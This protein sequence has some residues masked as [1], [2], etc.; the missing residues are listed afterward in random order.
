MAKRLSDTEKWMDSWFRRLPTNGKI[1]WLYILDRCD[2]A[3][4]WEVDYDLFS[5]L[6]GVPITAQEAESMLGDRIHLFDDG[7]KIWVRKFIDF[8]NGPLREESESKI[9]QLIIR[10]LKAHDLWIPYTMGINT[11]KDRAIVKERVKGKEKE[12]ANE[13]TTEL[14]IAFNEARLAYPGTRRGFKDEWA[15][16]LSRHG[17]NKEE[18]VPLLMAGVKRY[19]RK[20]AEDKTQKQYIKNFQGWITESRWTE[21]YP[22]WNTAKQEKAAQAGMTDEERLRE[23]RRKN[24][25]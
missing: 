25:I 23:W 14:E 3:G 17:K 6:S 12:Q 11:H 7:R 20:L 18:I 16:F 1:L 4:V 9:I 24:V 13:P 19:A 22:E 8:Q 2:I 15:H 10:T 5:L 21:E